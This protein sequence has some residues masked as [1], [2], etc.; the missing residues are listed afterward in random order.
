MRKVFAAATIAFLLSS[1][2]NTHIGELLST[3]FG[4]NEQQ[5]YSKNRNVVFP[6]EKFNEFKIGESKETV[7]RIFGQPDGDVAV[8][9]SKERDMFYLTDDGAFIP[10][11]MRNYNFR[12]D[13]KGI[14]VKKFVSDEG[15]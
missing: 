10:S 2:G 4:S 5:Y 1:C 11:I 8:K 13:E 14:I 9:D 12:Y 3:I 7:I 15:S 6:V